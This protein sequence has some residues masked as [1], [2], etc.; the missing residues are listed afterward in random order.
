MPIPQTG[1]H[2]A[3]LREAVATEFRAVVNMVRQALESRLS[4]GRSD[5]YINLEAV[6]PDRAVVAQ[7]GRFYAYPYTLSDDNQV[8]L[9]E[10]AEVVLD[11]KPVTLREA[12]FLE[13]VGEADSGK[14]LI[15]VMRSGLSANGNFY[16]DTV[17]RESAPLFE[18]ARVFIKSDAEHVKGGGKDVRN[19][20][21]GLSGVKFVEGGGPDLG[22]I[23]ALLTLIE[24]SGDVAVKLREASARGLAGLFGFS[25]DADGTAKTQLRE[26]RKVRVAQSI[27]R[28]S[29]VDLIVEPA[30]GGELIRMVESTHPQED[31][32]MSLRQKM[33]DTIKAKA[34]SA[35]AK[36][37]PD[38]ASDDELEV[39]YREAVNAPPARVA[40]AAGDNG[41]GLGDVEERIRMV[42]ARADMRATVAGCNL[43][44]AAKDRIRADFDRRERFVEADVTAAIEGER[45]YLAKFTES[46]KI[47]LGEFGSGA[48]AEDRSVKMAGMLD[49]FFDPAH[50]DHKSVGSFRECY[51]E[52][53]GDRHVTGQ[54]RD[55]D[56]A[57]LRDSLGA[58]F[59][60][61]LDTTSWADA[62]G[63]SITRRMQAIYEGQTDLQAWRRV[64]A[65]GR[66]NDFRSQER[67]RVG[68]Y[69]NLPAVA[70]GADYTALTSP[71]DD[72]ASF[73][74]SKRGGLETVTLEMIKND[75][76]GSIRRIPAELALSAGNTLY[77]FVFDFFRTNPTIYDS[78]ALYHASHGNLF[79]AALDATAFA[80]HRLAMVKQTRAGS[81]KRLG[82]TPAIV[83]VPFE[84]EETAYNLF[85][86]NTNLDETFVQ[87][88]KPQVIVPAYWTDAND[89]C[90]VADPNRM[91]AVEVSFLDGQEQPEL[92]VQNAPNVGS[93]FSADKIT[94]KIRHI[95]GGAVL[96]DGFKATTKA[97]VA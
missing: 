59:A 51:I 55:C 61:A 16:P 34:P 41:G 58:R 22:E 48:R 88:M 9:G 97:V 62:L 14:W 63:D 76:V 87:S 21:G 95:Y 50:K 7:N 8:T 18:G 84:L 73:A 93:L 15:R 10:P 24:P 71:G 67:I 70:Q 64:A 5:V 32:D 12:V 74:V 13:A 92:F 29:S 6:Y 77:E 69:G 37:N 49:A 40:P 85:Q 4:P 78:V 43:P 11:H 26:G 91:P 20:V 75:D 23:Q 52:F 79:T 36:L 19:L 57:K 60:E 33:L 31:R 17:L 1:L 35:Y 86:R 80:A 72:K 42:E 44:D 39:A 83:L 94:Y 53:T 90:T 30:A 38:T 68:G 2:G 46:G 81:S 47:A 89:W 3:Q 96:V 25:I 27:T 82:T 66:A 54:L 65:V 45:S 56:R 28:V